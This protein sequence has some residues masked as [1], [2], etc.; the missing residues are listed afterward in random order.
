MASI[1]K[2][3]VIFSFLLLFVFFAL[4]QRVVFDIL[5]GGI[6]FV[7][8]TLAKI[9]FGKAAES[10]ASLFVEGLGTFAELLQKTKAPLFF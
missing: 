4:I 1:L 10:I 2:F 7:F 6:V 3:L 9:L 5:F 8:G